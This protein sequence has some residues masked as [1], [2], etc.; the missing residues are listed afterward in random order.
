MI[1]QL[2]KVAEQ[3]LKA[4]LVPFI[5]RTVGYGPNHSANTT[6]RDARDALATLVLTWVEALA[7]GREIGIY[8]SDVSGAFDRVS[9]DRLVAKLRAPQIHQKVISVL[10]FWLRRR[11]AHVVARGKMSV[12]MLLKDMVFQGA[13]LGPT[14]WNLFFEDARKTLNEWFFE[15]AVYADDLHAYRVFMPEVSNATI[16]DTIKSCQIEL[17]AWGKANQ[18]VFDATKENNHVLSLPEPAGNYWESHL[19]F[20]SQ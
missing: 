2:S 15:E 7:R 19:I 4:L 10:T 11:T 18:V 13:V 16:G 6:G 20:S 8:C 9:V 1:A 14:L 5:T 3:L 17:H 12:A